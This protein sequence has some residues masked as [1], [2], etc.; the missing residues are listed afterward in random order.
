MN[1]P[2]AI[3]AGA[4]KCGTTSLSKFLST[5]DEVCLTSPKETLYWWRNHHRRPYNF[6]GKHYKHMTGKERVFLEASAYTAS[7]PYAIK[8]VPKDADVIYCVREPISRAYSE[9]LMRSLV[10]PGHCL[11]TFN[12]EVLANLSTYSIHNCQSEIDLHPYLDV[13]GGILKRI[14]IEQGA[15][16]THL[17][18]MIRHFKTSPLV[19]DIDH[20][21][22]SIL[23]VCDFLGIDCPMTGMPL[24]NVSAHSM[25]RDELQEFECFEL[26][27]EIYRPEVHLLSDTTGVDYVKEW[28]YR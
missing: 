9:W 8:R 1:L 25:S 15:Y 23:T 5:S 12:R 28:G 6:F 10:M 27:D 18:R 16:G 13:N 20:L 4:P 21:S 2:N 24:D 17:S 11:P 19:I 22:E 26:L 14:I 3:I 7:I